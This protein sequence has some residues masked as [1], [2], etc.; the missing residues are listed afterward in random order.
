MASKTK[1]MLALSALIA[2]GAGC[3]GHSIQRVESPESACVYGNIVVDDAY[4]PN[5]VIM[6]EVGVVYVPPFASPPTAATF[7]NGDFFFDNVKPGRYN[8]ASFMVGNDMYACSPTSDAE[9]APMIFEVKSG[10]RFY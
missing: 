1:G 5:N 10:A 3:G 6:H 8:L 4:V 7:D 9:L 2:A